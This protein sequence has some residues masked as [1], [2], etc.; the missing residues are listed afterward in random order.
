M[1]DILALLDYSG[2]HKRVLQKWR[3][4]HDSLSGA[5]IR[6]TKMLYRCRTYRNIYSQELAAQH[7]VYNSGSMSISEN[8]ART[9]T[10]QGKSGLGLGP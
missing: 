6:P 4:Y 9:E 8:L 3:F 7:N 5:A 1:P 10:L 2:F